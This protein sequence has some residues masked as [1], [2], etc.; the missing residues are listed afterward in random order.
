M[1][2]KLIERSKRRQ[3]SR[4]GLAA[5]RK[6]ARPVRS[7]CR[8]PAPDELTVRYLCGSQEMCGFVGILKWWHVDSQE[9]RRHQPIQNERH[10][11]PLRRQT[12]EAKPTRGRKFSGELIHGVV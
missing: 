8:K 2:E 11:H 3:Q 6:A 4:V 7:Y 1:E 10:R 5:R 12:L 9:G